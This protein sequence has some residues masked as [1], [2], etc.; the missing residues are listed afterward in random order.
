VCLSIEV[1]CLSIAG[2]LAQRNAATLL[3][4]ISAGINILGRS[5]RG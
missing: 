4:A 5:R 2:R 3:H 1:V